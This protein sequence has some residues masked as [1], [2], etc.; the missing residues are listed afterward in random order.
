MNRSCEFLVLILQGQSQKLC[1]Y[2]FVCDVL[3]IKMVS[4]DHQPILRVIF[5]VPHES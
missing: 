2:Y 3:E 5:I 1:F 4:T